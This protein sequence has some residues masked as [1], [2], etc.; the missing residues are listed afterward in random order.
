MYENEK[1]AFDWVEVSRHWSEEESKQE[2]KESNK[3]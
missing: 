3:K 1:G 2:G